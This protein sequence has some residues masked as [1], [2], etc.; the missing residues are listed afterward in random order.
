MADEGNE[1]PA[2][3]IVVAWRPESGHPA[4]PDAVLDGEMQFAV[5][6]LLRIVLPH[7]RWSRIHSLAAHSV[8]AAV[9][10]VARG[11]VIRPM[12]H[13]LL[14]D[15]WCRCNGVLYGLVA[16][17]DSHGAHRSGKLGFNQPRWCP[18]TKAMMDPPGN[19]KRR[20]DQRDREGNVESSDDAFYLVH[21]CVPPPFG[22]LML[23]AGE[24]VETGASSAP[25]SV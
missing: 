14:E 15:L 18:R 17:W 24:P 19:I 13:T 10:G 2:I 23:V 7:I 12:R 8:A 16:R 21:Y 22:G 4:Q 11:A 5:G 3:L 9:V 6:H 1:F 20:A 25:L